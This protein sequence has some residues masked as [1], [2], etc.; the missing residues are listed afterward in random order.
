M[1]EHANESGAEQEPLKLAEPLLSELSKKQE[2]LSPQEWKQL[3]ELS[4]ELSE[5]WSELYKQLSELSRQENL[6]NS[7]WNKREL[8]SEAQVEKLQQVILVQSAA[9]RERRENISTQL[10][11]KLNERLERERS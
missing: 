2:P 7:F 1:N 4:E 5:P 11:K 3:D 9:I 6:L 10:R 8:F